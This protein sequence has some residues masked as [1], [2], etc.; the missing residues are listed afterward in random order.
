MRLTKLISFALCFLFGSSAAEPQF[1]VATND[2]RDLAPF[3]QKHVER[4]KFPALAAAVIQ[5]T[6]IIA[7]GISGVRKVGETNAATLG[8]KF[9]IGSITKSMT[10]LLAVRLEQKGVIHLTNRVGSVLKDWQLP[11]PVNAITL[12]HLLQNRSGIGNERDPELWKKA[13]EES[14][15]APE[16]RRRFL[17]GQLKT[18]LEAEPG[19]KYIYSNFGFALAGAMLETAAKQPWEDLV[20]AEIFPWI[21]LTS[22]GFGPPGTRSLDQPWGHVWQDGEATPIRPFDNPTAIAPAGA[23]HLSILDAARYA[24]FHLA[25]ARGKIDPLKSH[26]QALYTPPADLESDYALGWSVQDRPWADGE[27]LNHTGSNTMFFMV[28]WIAPKKDLA[29]VVAT[30][31]GD[32]QNHVAGECDRV[33]AELIREYS[34]LK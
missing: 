2:L 13:F 24:A 34:R 4:T 23:V 21:G 7:A 8:D 31:I 19:S 12:Q 15:P 27:T 28:I 6:N 26:R 25:A 5:G 33:V 14:G 10:A 20:K 16:Q 17:T 30:N 9:H 22:A 18:P 3:L 29:W 32:R 11:A 1:Q